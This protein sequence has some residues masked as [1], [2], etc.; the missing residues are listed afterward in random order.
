MKKLLL[1]ACLPFVFISCNKEPKE[2]SKSEKLR[3][4]V[5]KIGGYKVKYYDSTLAIDSIHD[6][7]THNMTNCMKDNRMEFG[8]NHEGYQLMYGD[9]CAPGELA[10]ERFDWE[11]TNNETVMKLYNINQVLPI[12]NLRGDILRWDDTAINLRYY[13]YPDTPDMLGDTLTYSVELRN[14]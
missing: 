7:Y 8:V 12:T 10:K 2:K 6:I 5:W 11:L 1:L 9:A 3:A 14:N 4:S 13:E